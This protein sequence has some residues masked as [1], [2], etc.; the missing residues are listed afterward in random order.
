MSAAAS[1]NAAPALNRN[2][3]DA[4]AVEERDA[5]ASPRTGRTVSSRIVL[6]GLFGCGN[7]GNDG[8]LETM[9]GFLR[10]VR[11]HA[12]I[13]C[14]CDEPQVVSRSLNVDAVP[15]RQPGELV[16]SR[17]AWILRQPFRKLRDFGH[18]W[19]HLSRADVMII[20]GTGILDD[21]GERPQGMP[22][23]LLTWCLAARLC[24]T[25]IAFVCIG[26]GPIRRRVNRWLMLSAASLAHYRSY[27]DGISKEFMGSV[28][29]D[30]A[31]DQVYPDIVFK[32]PAP[33]ARPR[34]LA[35]FPDLTIGVGVMSYRG[36]YGYAE[37]GDR[38]FAR[39]I[40]KLSEFVVHLLD[41]AYGVRLLTGELGDRTAVDALLAGVR[42]ARP[43]AARRIAAEPSYSLGDL[44]EQMS[45]TD[46]VVATRFHNIVC[47]LK[48]GKPTISLGYAKKNDVLMAEMGLADYCQHIEHFDVPALIEQ[49]DRLVE[50]RKALAR[51]VRERVSDFDKQLGRQEELLLS[52]LI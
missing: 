32:L 20:P 48:M 29:F 2:R 34:S 25:K 52:G 41:G 10:R 28:G 50:D 39:Y 24:G 51:H 12:G 36:W 11:P 42:A 27:R 26:A 7:L 6:F 19:H 35:D 30:T 9:L 8:S 4:G 46:I 5:A 49:F 37:G 18:A 3:A 14:V 31:G 21:F 33:E 45:R 1:E 40:E 13:V 15:I 38:I 23:K 47:A 43:E 44:M 16:G 17:I 22:L